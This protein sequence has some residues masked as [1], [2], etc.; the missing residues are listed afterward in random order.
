MARKC[1]YS[2]YYAEDSWRVSTVK[3]IGAIEGQAL[4]SANEFEEIKRKGDK[5]VADWIAGNMSGRS[6][7]I[8][9]IGS[10]TASRPG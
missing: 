4:V 2:F 7:V 8:V 10:N 1:F 6:T 5:A 3:N 9:L